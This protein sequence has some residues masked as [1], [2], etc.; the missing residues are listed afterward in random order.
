MNKSLLLVTGII[1]S[2]LLLTTPLFSQ[3]SLVKDINTAPAGFRP[4]NDYTELF[5]HCGE[6]LFFTVP[7]KELWRTDGTPAGTISL[8]DINKG[9]TQGVPNYFSSMTCSDNQLLYF[10]GNDGLHGW[11][12]WTSDGTE[13]GTAMLKDVTPGLGENGGGVSLFGMLGDT[14]Y[15][16]TDSDNNKEKELWKSNGTSNTTVMVADF[17]AFTSASYVMSSDTHHFFRTTNP[18]TEKDELWATDGTGANTIKLNDEFRFGV[19]ANL[20]AKVMYSENDRSNNTY[21][22]WMSDGTNGGT[23]MVKDFG[24]QYLQRF[25]DFNDKLLFGVYGETWISDG[26]EAGTTFL[27]SGYVDASITIDNYFYG[28]G[29]DFSSGSYRLFKTDGVS[30]ETTDFHYGNLGDISMHHDIPVIGNNLFFQ[31]ADENVG[32]EPGIYNLSTGSF[33]LIEDIHPGVNGSSPRAWSV[34]DGRVYFLADDGISGVEI[35]TTDG[36]ADGTHLLKHILNETASAFRSTY[37]SLIDVT[38]SEGKLQLLVE[39]QPQKSAIYTSDGTESRTIPKIEFDIPSLTMFGRAGNDLIYFND[40]KFYKTNGATEVVTLVKDVSNDVNSLGYMLMPHYSL[41]DKLIFKFGVYGGNLA[42]GDEFW[43]TDGTEAG[44]HILKDINP[45]LPGGVSNEAAILG[46]KLIFQ[47]TEPSSGSELWVTDG[48]EAGTVLLKDINPGAEGS[49]VHGFAV[50]GDK[51]IFGAMEVAYGGEVWITDGT[52]AGTTLLADIVPGP[53]GSEARHFRAGDNFVF[54]S[55]YDAEKGWTSWRTDGTADGTMMIVDVIPGNNKGDYPINLNVIGDKFYFG[56]N[57]EVHGPEL[58]VTDGTVS[59]THILDV[60][61]GSAG[62]NPLLVTDINGVAYFKGDAS[63]WRTNGTAQGTFKVS[64]LEPF[65]ITVLNN[66]V[67]FTA[68]H[69]DYGIELFKVEFTKLNQEIIADAVQEKTF[70]DSPFQIPASA[71]SGLPVEVAS[72]D[73]LMVENNAAVILKPGTVAITIRQ[74]GDALFNAAAEV[75]YTFCVLPAKPEISVSGVSSAEPFLTS[76]AE[77]GNQWFADNVEV[78]GANEKVY[79]PEESSVFKV[80]VTIDGC[81][82]PFS[83]EEVVLITGIP[84]SEN[85]LVFYPNPAKDHIKIQA[86]G[87]QEK[88]QVNIVD[89]QGKAIENFQIRTNES[90]VHSLRSYQPGIYIIEIVTSGGTVYN[91]FVKE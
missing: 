77:T 84:E 14:F 66:W 26:T 73:E 16:V 85:Q 2:M 74:N 3:E 88:V 29:Y 41:G 59:G 36:T 21:S 52:A 58:W 63:L 20:G 28:L 42:F 34:L 76:S 18:L 11:E 56:A 25:D 64:N 13:N 68:L 33:G 4:T 44:T 87:R 23:V 6:Y 1:A 69:P 45:G 60:V 38:P 9:Y 89:L 80:N 39:P 75:S 27:T 35:W 19:W 86:S 57:D 24:N 51:V 43:I 78:A 47:G 37:N 62:S 17:P 82:S 32:Q 10:I 81:T 61:P 55:A 83:D 70:G 72:S 12:I 49:S 8:G 46:S 65:Y 54:F 50:F 22:L 79:M 71:T 90:V 91:K 40:R 7:G 31:Y 30:V 48:T 5:C 67:Y 53:V 15:F